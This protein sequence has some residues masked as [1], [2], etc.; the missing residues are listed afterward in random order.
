MKKS[1][2]LFSALL[3]Y[4]VGLMAQTKIN[5]TDKN[6]VKHTY[7]KK[8]ISIVTTDDGKVF[9]DTSETAIT[10]TKVKALYDNLLS[11]PPVVV[12]P[13]IVVQPPV[14]ALIV[15]PVSGKSTDLGI[16]TKN[17]TIKP[18]VYD[19]VYFTFSKA[20][21]VIIDFT[22]VQFNNSV[23]E[24]GS[25][26][27]VVLLNLVMNTQKY[28]A[29]RFDYGLNNL[30]IKGFKF[31]NCGDYV[32]TSNNSKVQYNGNDL[33][34]NKGLKIINSIFD[35]CGTI[36]LGNS[37]DVN[38]GEDAGIFKDVEISGNTFKNSSPGSAVSLTNVWGYDIF[39]NVVDNFNTIND[40]HNGI[41]LMQGNGKFH[42]NKLTN[43]QGNSIRMWLYSRGTTPFTNEIYNNICY[44]TRKYGAFELQEFSRNIW[45]NRT[46][47]AN[48]KV[49]NNTGGQLNTAKDWEGQILDLYQLSGTVEYYNNLGFNLNTVQYQKN[50]TNMINNMSGTKIVKES[51]NLYFPTWEKAVK[52]LNSFESLNSGVG[53]PKK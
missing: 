48:A 23:L 46:T 21:D 31:I 43:Y 53:A 7:T 35:G 6:R 22:G 10:A 2:L 1:I 49:Y 32:I 11:K 42:D 13:P 15:T 47:F 24:L 37:I 18:G 19:N 52:D 28:R 12:V 26:N 29:L 9:S 3:T 5:F 38:T 14:N 44:N 20:N 8:V 50:V 17:T 16:V 27:N 41:F 30:T 45:K 34:L 25:G 40:L 4:S 51:N 33:S 36:S 39:N